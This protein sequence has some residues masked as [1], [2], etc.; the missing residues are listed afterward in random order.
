MKR[1]KGSK[2]GIN[3]QV[4]TKIFIIVKAL[5]NNDFKPHIEI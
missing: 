2:Q 1:L 4:A 5:R 3:S